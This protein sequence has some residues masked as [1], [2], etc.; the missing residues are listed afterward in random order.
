MN[1]FPQSIS[2]K[3]SLHAESASKKIAF[4]MSTLTALFRFSPSG[5]QTTQSKERKNNE[6]TDSVQKNINSATCRMPQSWRDLRVGNKRLCSEP[7]R[8]SSGP[9]IARNP[10]I[11]AR[12]DAE[13]LRFGVVVSPRP[14][15]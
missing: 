7:L 15:L 11:H 4:R 10:P 9:S 14:G 13:Y 5:S 2:L 6:S 1:P 12:W 8:L 3:N